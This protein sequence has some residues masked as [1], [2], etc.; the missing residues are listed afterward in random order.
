MGKETDLP[1]VSVIVPVYNGEQTVVQCVEFLLAQDYPKDP[2]EIIFVDNKSNDHTCAIL[3]PY[4]ESGKILLLSEANVLNAY[5]AH[6]TGIRSTKG[7][8]LAFTEADCEAEPEW[9]FE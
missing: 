2:L 9:H 4:V 8:I 7:G 6:N 5:G 3:Q 1:F